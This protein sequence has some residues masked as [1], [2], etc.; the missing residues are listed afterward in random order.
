MAEGLTP[1]ACRSGRATGSSAPA[2][3]TS[4]KVKL[5]F[6]KGASLRDSAGLFNASLDAGQRRAIDLHVGDELDETA[7]EDLV[8]SAAELERRVAG[9]GRGDLRS[10]L[11]TVPTHSR[12][13]P[14]HRSPYGGSHRKATW[15]GTTETQGRPSGDR[16]G[17]RPRP[18]RLPDRHPLRRG[19]ELRPDLRPAGVREA[20]AG[21]GE[22]HDP[23]RR[24]HPGA[25]PIGVAHER[26][27]S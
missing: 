22:A 15:R 10:Q 9:R 20:R 18:P 19:L 5:T 26:E 6:A 14:S 17:A 24:S 16:G 1:T 25:L 12:L 11:A 2:R 4:D 3:R 23:S 21:A 27:G 8:R 13:D 7:F